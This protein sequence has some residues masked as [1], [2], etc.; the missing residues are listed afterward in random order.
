MNDRNDRNDRNSSE[1]VDKLIGVRRVAKTVKGGRRMSFG[2]LVVIGDEN[3]RVGW[4]KGKA[5]EVPEAVRKATEEAK[6]AMIRVPL[7]QGRTLHHEVLGRFGATKV[8]LKPAV[9]GTGIIAGGA[10]RAVFEAMGIKDVVCKALGSTNEYN[11]IQATFAA[12]AD[13]ETPRSIAAKRGIKLTDLLLHKE[14]ASKGEVDQKEL[15]AEAAEQKKT[16]KAASTKPAAKG[17]TDKPAG[18]PRKEEKPAKA[19]MQMV[20][21]TASLK[22][23]V[24]KDDAKSEAPKA[25]AAAPAEAPVAEAK[26]E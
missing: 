23:A 20:S 6:R 5:K 16:N 7:R 21:K 1:F 8:V 9:P 19:E 22:Q 25:E 11:L 4:G 14:E 26:S 15:N 18:K 24:G 12:F 3:G 13:M 17:R 10:M 2:A